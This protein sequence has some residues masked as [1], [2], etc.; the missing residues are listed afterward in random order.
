[1]PK[2]Y[3]YTEEAHEKLLD[4]QARG[5]V[6]DEIFSRICNYCKEHAREESEGYLVDREIVVD[7]WSSECPQLER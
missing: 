6:S 7:A 1:M 3:I 5:S 4:Y 2:Q